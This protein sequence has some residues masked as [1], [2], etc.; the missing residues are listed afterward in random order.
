MVQI[1]SRIQKIRLRSWK[2]FFWKQ[3][4][5]KF[6]QENTVGEK[7]EINF[8]ELL[9]SVLWD[10]GERYLK[11]Y[12]I[13]SQ[14]EWKEIFCLRPLWN[15]ENSGNNL[16]WGAQDNDCWQFCDAMIQGLPRASPLG[17]HWRPK[18]TPRPPALNLSDTE[19]SYCR[20]QWTVP[21]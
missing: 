3:Y 6:S 21:W 11:I 5:D 14:P 15:W 16:A 8:L 4:S 9:M 2:V 17:P 10:R 12:P 7:V 18:S 20:G 1:L 13:F 19:L